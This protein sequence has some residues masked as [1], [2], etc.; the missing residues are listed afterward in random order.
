MPA[1]IDWSTVA[2]SDL[3]PE[4]AELCE[5]VAG[6][7]SPVE[8]AERIVS[9]FGGGNLYVPALRD[10]RRRHLARQA[11]ALFDPAANGGKGNASAVARRL[12][13]SR[14]LVAGLLNR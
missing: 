13:V 9:A 3:P 5:T 6:A 7:S 8:A 4:L 14:R 12:G 1:Q 11:A 2:L 10:L